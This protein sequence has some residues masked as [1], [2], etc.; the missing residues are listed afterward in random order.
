M[1]VKGAKNLKHCA[2]IDA[3]RNNDQIDPWEE[4]VSAQN[5]EKIEVTFQQGEDHAQRHQPQ[6]NKD[7]HSKTSTNPTRNLTST[8]DLQ[9]EMAETTNS[10]LFRPALKLRRKK[11]ASAFISTR[12]RD[13][14]TEDETARVQNSTS[15]TDLPIHKHRLLVKNMR[16]RK[17]IM[18][19]GSTHNY[20]DGFWMHWFIHL[21]W[22]V[23]EYYDDG[24]ENEKAELNESDFGPAQDSPPNPVG[25]PPSRLTVENQAQNDAPEILGED[26]EVIDQEDIRSSG[27]SFA[28][29]LW[30]CYGGDTLFTQT[31]AASTRCLSQDAMM[32]HVRMKM[33][34]EVTS[35]GYYYYIFYS[36][37]DIVSN[38]IFARFNIE[39]VEYS[40]P[41]YTNSCINS[42]YCSMPLGFFS[43]EK[44]LLEVPL[45]DGVSDEDALDQMV[46]ISTCRPRLAVYLFF[47][48]AILFSILACA[49]I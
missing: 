25:L 9:K 40:F 28:K 35:T 42:T 20:S 30:S 2:L 33:V 13:E 27:S 1:V 43:S 14:K 46:L 4:D 16:T 45:Q 37:N 3:S 18:T 21:N 22:F 36:D 17:F 39:K 19:E 49:F 34:H 47:P 26:D 8:G 44:V 6:R 38:D 29:N 32:K 11:S 41:N 7:A 48:V 24:D 5:G 23:D 12:D 15:N 10:S 31:F